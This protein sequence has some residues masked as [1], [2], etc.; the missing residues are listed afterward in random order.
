MMCK[1]DAAN[2]YTETVIPLLFFSA[3][4]FITG[5]GLEEKGP[6]TTAPCGL[7]SSLRKNWEYNYVTLLY[8]RN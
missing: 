7:A 3:A 1:G 4:A 6:E 8:S 5:R 2:T